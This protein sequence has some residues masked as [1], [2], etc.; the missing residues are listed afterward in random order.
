MMVLLRSNIIRFTAIC[1]VIFLPKGVA[2]QNCQ[3]PNPSFENFSVCPTFLGQMNLVDNWRSAGAGTPDYF[4]CNYSLVSNPLG[5]PVLPISQLPDGLGYAGT[6]RFV[7]QPNSI[8]FVEYIGVALNTPFLAGV[9][10][11]FSVSV[12]QSQTFVASNLQG[13]IDLAL[14][15]TPNA[16]ELPW[17][18]VTCPIGIGSWQLLA[19]AN[20]SP[21]AFGVWDN[22]I[23]TFTPSVDINA[24]AIGGTCS[25]SL[26][27]SYYVLYDNISCS[28]NL[29]VELTSFDVE[30]E[31]RNSVVQWATN[32]EYNNDYFLI[33]KT[34]D[35]FN[36][37]D[38]TEI[39]GVG[40]TTIPQEYQFI[41]TSS[42]DDC[43]SN[44]YYRLKQYDLDGTVTDYGLK[45]SKCNIPQGAND[46]NI[47]I[48][49]NQVTIV[50]EA[51]FEY[52]IYDHLG[53]KVSS[54]TAEGTA[55]FR[56]NTLSAG[57]YYMVATI[58]SNGVSVSKKMV[59]M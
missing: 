48:F 13:T 36:Y 28:S 22:I 52:T 58:K 19:N 12:A 40:T 56:L 38:V 43:Q 10:Y 32:T 27:T 50:S 4:N 16:S 54:D 6:I 30:C 51:S 57:L 53:N 26:S 17:N 47:S 2:S 21:A 18:T 8:D 14:F 44:V 31:G 59:K 35:G 9:T 29:P 3:I 25:P 45:V 11:S 5:M 23:F 39:N 20:F 41:D 46:I 33:E 55:S 24:I 37:E 42:V 34:C 15:G 49:E 7:L 1:I